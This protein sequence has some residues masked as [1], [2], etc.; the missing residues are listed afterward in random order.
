[1]LLMFNLIML[2]LSILYSKVIN[3]ASILVSMGISHLTF[4]V[5]I[6]WRKKIKGVTKKEELP[7]VKLTPLVLKEYE[8]PIILSRFNKTNKHKKGE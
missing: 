4:S 5:F 1:M 2:L 6:Y 8:V 7:E 3:P